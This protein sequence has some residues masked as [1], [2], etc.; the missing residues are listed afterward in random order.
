MPPIPPEDKGGGVRK[1][2]PP[3]DAEFDESDASMG[4]GLLPG[5]VRSIALDGNTLAPDL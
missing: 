3:L 5:S 2:G 1:G 4:F